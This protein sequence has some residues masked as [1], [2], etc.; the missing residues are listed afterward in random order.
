MKFINN[1]FENATKESRRRRRGRSKL[2]KFIKAKTMI[3]TNKYLFRKPRKYQKKGSANLSTRI[4]LCTSETGSWMTKVLKSRKE[5]ARSCSQGPRTQ[6]DGSLGEKN[7]TEN[8]LMTR[9]LA[10]DFTNTLEAAHTMVSGKME[11]WTGKERWSMLTV[12]LTTAI[13]PTTKWMELV[14]TSMLTKSH[15]ME[16]SLRVNLTAVF[17]NVS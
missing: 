13:G 11:W 4:S 7:M 10:M 14:F 1:I 17:K 5:R 6:W 12:H 2:H 8:G 9:C 3:L 15:G 16:F